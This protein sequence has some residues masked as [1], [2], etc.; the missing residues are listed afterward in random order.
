[1]DTYIE[2]IECIYL[3]EY[4]F[5]RQRL[6]LRVVSN[7][8]QVTKPSFAAMVRDSEI[9]FCS[10]PTCIMCAQ[11]KMNFGCSDYLLT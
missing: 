1:M 9:P 2:L 8:R 7:T 11:Y 3:I 4:E 6:F 5:S 10:P